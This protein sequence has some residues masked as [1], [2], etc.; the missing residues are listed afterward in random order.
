MEKKTDAIRKWVLAIILCTAAFFLLR[1]ISG[2]IYIRNL[3]VVE[4]KTAQSGTLRKVIKQSGKLSFEEESEKFFSPAGITVTG[5]LT[6]PGTKVLKGDVILRYEYDERSL[7]IQ[8]LTL[9]LEK[10]KWEEAKKRT[11]N[12]TEKKLYDLYIEQVEEK[13]EVM[14]L[15]LEGE[16]CLRASE[17]GCLVYTAPL[18]EAAEGTCLTEIVLAEEPTLH[19]SYET[20][21]QSGTKASELTMQYEEKTIRWTILQQTTRGDQCFA[22]A[23]IPFG[24]WGK[25]AC[26]GEEITFSQVISADYEWTIPCS[27][28]N[29]QSEDKGYIYLLLPTESRVGVREAELIKTSVV[30]LDSDGEWAAITKD[31]SLSF[32]GRW[33]EKLEDGLIVRVRDE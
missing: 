26:S 8:Q 22:E 2:Q 27:A 32:V 14:R 24:E 29:M 15:I 18:G 19:L 12:E 3:P 5:I 21:G 7:R 11:S 25:A 31:T 10:E 28:L 33:T 30:L 23:R 9:E 20:T 17:D 13:L 1:Y 16:G 6:V 4:E